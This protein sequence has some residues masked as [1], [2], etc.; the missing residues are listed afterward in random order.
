[1]KTIWKFKAAPLYNYKSIKETPT[2]DTLEKIGI[3]YIDDEKMVFNRSL[4]SNR[5]LR[6]FSL[7]FICIIG[8]FS[9]LLFKLI[10]GVNTYVEADTVDRVF[11]S[12]MC[13]IG[14]LPF[15]YPLAYCIWCPPRKGIFNRHTGTVSLPAPWLKGFNGAQITLQ[16]RDID[17]IVEGIMQRIYV[18]PYP[19][20]K[21]FHFNLGFSPGDT[22]S[23]SFITWYM[24][25]NRPLPPGEILDSYRQSDFERRKAEGFPLPVYE[26]IVETP[27]VTPAQQ[28]ERSKKWEG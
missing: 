9:Y 25:K 21:W 8:W 27:E 4:A 18:I 11:Y 12:I 17:F 16:Y 5:V 3:E 2:I 22:K 24:D 13:I 23:I 28:K 10:T 6:S 26:S 7:V 20:N 14:I 19:K 15:L 1:M